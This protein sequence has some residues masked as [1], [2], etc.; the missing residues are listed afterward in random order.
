MSHILSWVSRIKQY[1]CSVYHT[2]VLVFRADNIVDTKKDY[3]SLVETNFIFLKIH[4][5]EIFFQ[6]FEDI[7]SLWS[8]GPETQD[9]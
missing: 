9:F 1:K 4:K 5:H 3:S 8:P 2:T 6:L 7:Q